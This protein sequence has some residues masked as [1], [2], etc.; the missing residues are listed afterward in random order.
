MVPKSLADEQWIRR[1]QPW[2]NRVNSQQIEQIPAD[3]AGASWRWTDAGESWPARV[4]RGSWA[5]RGCGRGRG[6]GVT[7]QEIAVTERTRQT[8]RMAAEKGHDTGG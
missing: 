3:L 2:R 8:T 5:A 4:A 1:L 7:T 6:G